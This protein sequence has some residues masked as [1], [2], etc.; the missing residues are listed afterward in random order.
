MSSMARDRAG[1]RVM[2]VVRLHALPRWAAWAPHLV[3]AAAGRAAAALV[4]RC[5]ELDG[6]TGIIASE[7]LL[8]AADAAAVAG[9]G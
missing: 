2:V 6:A 5:D 7:L 9:V 3:A 1:S 8:R 4:V